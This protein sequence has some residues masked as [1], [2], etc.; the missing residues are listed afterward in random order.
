MSRA[1]PLRVLSSMAGRKLLGDLIA[2]FEATSER[3]VSLESVGG[4]DAAKRVRAG[5]PLDVVVLAREVIDDLI[6][7]ARIAPGSRVDIWVS[8]IGVAVRAGAAR[9]DIS[10]AAGVRAAV[11][12]ARKVGYSTGPS[13]QY[14]AKLFAG[15]D[16]DGKLKD[17]I[18]VAPPG[19]PV[20][21]L[22]ARGE[23]EIAFQQLSELGGE[24]IEIVGPLP[25]DIQ[26]VTTFSGG[27]ALSST[28]PDAA[29]ALLAFFG[30]PAVRGVKQA[31]GM[32]AP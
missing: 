18:T 30:S 23:I 16:T 1:S 8:A 17:R 11:L 2:K 22:V 32:D 21:S 9:P 10:S 19:V 27:V 6:G 25:P 7:A 13:G 4:V 15:W 20:A 3:R 14:L 26:L 31:H 24:G 12:A 5:E 28:E 29:R